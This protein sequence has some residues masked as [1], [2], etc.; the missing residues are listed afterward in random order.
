MSVISLPDKQACFGP[1]MLSPVKGQ[2]LNKISL[3]TPVPV[4]GK[5]YADHLHK[6]PAGPFLMI[7]CQLGELIIGDV[8]AWIFHN[9]HFD[10]VTGFF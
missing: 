3:D 10:Q 7:S 2:T 4:V 9:I 6:Y 5:K 1:D 8:I